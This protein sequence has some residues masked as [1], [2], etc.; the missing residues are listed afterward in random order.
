MVHR[1][2]VKETKAHVIIRVIGLFLLFFFLFLLLLLSCRCTP[3]CPTPTGSNYCTTWYTHIH[4]HKRMWS[5]KQW[6]D[7]SYNQTSNEIILYHTD[8]K[9][10]NNDKFEYDNSVYPAR[11]RCTKLHAPPPSTPK[12]TK[13]MLIHNTFRSMQENQVTSVLSEYYDPHYIWSK[14]C[15]NKLDVKRAVLPDGMDASLPIPSAMT[16]LNTLP[17]NSDRTWGG[18]Q[19]VSI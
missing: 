18:N 9:D 4:R 8:N 11:K 7:P 19:K 6:T 17:F 13:L 10:P 5:C 3:A 12:I 2:L 14:C 1:C 15:T 16:S